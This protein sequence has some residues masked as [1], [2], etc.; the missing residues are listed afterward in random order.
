M[1][2]EMLGIGIAW[3]LF[4][5]PRVLALDEAPNALDNDTECGFMEAVKSLHGKLTILVVAH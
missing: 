5:R 3:A 1:T 4:H 2:L